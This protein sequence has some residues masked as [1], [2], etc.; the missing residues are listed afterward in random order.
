MEEVINKSP[1]FDRMTIYDLHARHVK[2]KEEYKKRYLLSLKPF[3]QEEKEELTRKTREI[4]NAIH[5]KMP[6]LAEIPWKFAKTDHSI[7]MGYPHT[8]E[9]YIILT[10]VPSISTL[11]HEKIHVFQR[12]YKHET[13]ELIRN[14][15][16]HKYGLY[17]D[18][19]LAR[20]N[21]D[22]DEFVYS[23]NGQIIYQKYNS[24]SPNDIS[25]S[26]VTIPGEYEHPYEHMA[27]TLQRQLL[28]DIN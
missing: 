19:P 20:N 26:K 1:F 6:L 14:Y 7:E 8:L 10:S 4:D 24:T 18:L 5:E 22:I 27:Y 16:F 25:D 2:T 9:D 11:L 23:R 12:L 13:E 3:T 28:P 21:P 17:S 15:G